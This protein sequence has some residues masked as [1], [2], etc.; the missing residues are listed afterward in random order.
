MQKTFLLVDPDHEY[1]IRFIDL[2]VER[3][4]YRPLCILCHSP[5]LSGRRAHPK[6]RPLERTYVPHA[7]LETFG[8]RIRSELDVQGAIPFSEAVLGPVLE[9]LRGLGST[10]NHP[11]VLAL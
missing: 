9:L 5:S 10:W 4:G 1:A 11:S 2:V 8:R 3:F 6:L 7:E